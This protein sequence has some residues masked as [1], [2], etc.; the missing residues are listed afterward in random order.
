VSPKIDPAQALEAVRSK[1]VA[2]RPELRDAPPL[3]PIAQQLAESL[4]AGATTDAAQRVASAQLSKVAA[5][6][7][8]VATVITAITDVSTI[9]AADLLGK[10]RGQLV[11]IGIAQ[12]PDRE[13]GDNAIWIALLVATPRP[14]S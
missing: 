4:A 13:L 3:H 2:A 10:A 12:G 7:A 5:D 9:D 6:Y 14:H 1:L 11:G 8:S